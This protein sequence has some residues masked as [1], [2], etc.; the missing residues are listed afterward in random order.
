M[1][2]TATTKVGESRAY[3]THGVQPYPHPVA[4]LRM[5]QLVDYDP[6]LTEP[7]R[8]VYRF[9]VG[10]YMDDHGDAL[11]SVRKIVAAMRG[12]APDGAKHLSRSAVQRA[13]ILLIDNNWLTRKELG[14]GRRGSRYVPVANVLELAAMGRLPDSVPETRDAT[15]EFSVPEKWD[16]CVPV[17]RDATADSVPPAGTKTRLQESL[18]KTAITCSEKDSSQVADALPRAAL[19][20]FER[21]A[22][23][24]DK[25]GDDMRKARQAFDAIAPDAAEL[26]RMLRSAEGWKR[27]A[28]GPRMALARW[29]TEKRWLAGEEWANDNRQVTRYPACVITKIKPRTSGDDFD[30]ATIWFRD[31][32]GVLRN[33][34]LDL[35]EFRTLQD[36]VDRAACASPSDDLHEFVGAHFQIDEAGHFDATGKEAA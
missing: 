12:R 13:I 6:R 28:R 31:R 17:E 5:S 1:S 10:W 18:T 35:R 23:A 33:Q 36:C 2:T 16:T 34:I 30:G 3:W 27:T 9:L 20:G 7:A 25:P 11:A 32:A 8:T 4:Q 21:L 29:L 26:E 19:G 24:Y 22:S 14:R 15:D